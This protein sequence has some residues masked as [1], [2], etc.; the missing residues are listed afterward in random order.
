MSALVMW[1]EFVAER[2]QH[3]GSVISRIWECCIQTGIASSSHLI[4]SA[5]FLHAEDAPLP[6]TVARLLESCAAGAATCGVRLETNTLQQRCLWADPIG[7]FGGK[8]VSKSSE[9]QRHS[10]SK[11]A[12][13][14]SRRDA[15]MET[16]ARGRKRRR[17][18]W[19]K[20]EDE[21]LGS[22]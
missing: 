20:G 12:R 22:D 13:T 19:R 21:A 7:L 3:L 5:A 6:A 8:S 1:K 16:E 15:A 17:Q 2:N 14:G 10:G 18:W 11:P 4:K 9:G